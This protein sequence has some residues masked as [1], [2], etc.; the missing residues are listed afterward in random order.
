M[1]HLEPEQVYFEAYD[2]QRHKTVAAL[3]YILF[4]LPLIS[5]KDSKF[6]MYHANQGLLLFLAGALCHTALG[7][8]P[9]IGWLAA[10][11]IHLLIGGLALLGIV[12]AVRGERSPLPLIG[13]VT[14]L[15]A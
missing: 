9:A 4:F 14:L 3:S 6:A 13:R 1:K 10:P 11:L 7:L 12:R 2:V 15:K 8:L 5:A